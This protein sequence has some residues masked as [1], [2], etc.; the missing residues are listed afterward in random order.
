MMKEKAEHPPPVFS[1]LLDSENSQAGI[2]PPQNEMIIT[3]IPIIRVRH[4]AVSGARYT[5]KNEQGGWVMR[6]LHTAD[7][8]LGKTI[9]GRDRQIEQ[10]QFIDEICTICDDEQVDVVLLAGDV[11]QTPN[12]SAAAE[13]LFY[14]ALDR[15]A[16]HGTRGIVVIAGNH[17]N[18]ERL[19]AP[20]PLADRLGI[21]LIGLP[22]DELQPSV[23]TGTERVTRVQCGA[24]WLEL[25][26]PGCD[27][28]AVIAALPY[29]SEGR[30][31]QLV[32]KSLHEE[33]LQQGYNRLIGA[34]MNNLALHFRSDTVNIAMSHLFVTGGVES[35]HESENQIQQ[36]GGIYAVD[37][38]AFPAH[39]QYIALG[40]LHRPQNMTSVVPCRYAGS[41]LPY[42]FAEVGHA[43]SVTIVEALPGSGAAVREICL[44]AGKPLVKWQAQ[45]LSQVYNWL[46]EGRDKNAWIDLE[47][48]VTQSITNDE[49]HKLRDLHPG[50]VNIRL[51]AKN[52]GE[53]IEERPQL[54]QLSSE[55][56]FRRFFERQKGG[57]QPDDGLVKLFLELTEQTDQADKR[58]EHS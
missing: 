12:P 16:C 47:V 13:E 23:R 30:I 45:G 57:L 26:V 49:I 40:H 6:I 37:A 58:G 2:R 29:P 42:S 7:W 54:S 14:D 9:E 33:E 48:S 43:K 22:K 50:L 39:A 27:H 4:T 41:P 38:A 46:D 20:S 18:P 1:L 3:I 31:R 32:A 24:S 19:S 17:D 28:S 25:V 11:F 55:E 35:G 8:H 34:T 44:S 56:L 10:E 15:L 5:E 51:I 53:S 52:G 36:V 21:T